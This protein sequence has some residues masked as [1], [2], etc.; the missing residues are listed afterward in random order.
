MAEPIC[1]PRAGRR[2]GRGETRPLP[3]TGRR[4]RAVVVRGRLGQGLG[5]RVQRVGKVRRVGQGTVGLG[6]A[7]VRH[8]PAGDGDCDR[9][10]GQQRGDHQRH[11]EAQLGEAHAVDLRHL[12]SRFCGGCHLVLL[13]VKS[14]NGVGLHHDLFSELT[15]LE[16]SAELQVGR[17]TFPPPKGVHA[18]AV[19]RWTGPKADADVALEPEVV[20][21]RKLEGVEPGHEDLVLRIVLPVVKNGSVRGAPVGIRHLVLRF[22]FVVH[23]L[24]YAPSSKPAVDLVGLNR[25]LEEQ[26]VTNLRAADFL[27]V[28]SADLHLAGR[29]GARVGDGARSGD[30]ADVES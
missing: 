5:R 24:R 21:A 12:G 15:F 11:D 1:V 25:D 30:H 22:L 4:R 9:H 29:R 3:E 27:A 20:A 16:G 2:G 23:R 6:A 28:E 18:V 19:H 26:V 13:L 10:Q 8:E 17:L 7:S 14:K